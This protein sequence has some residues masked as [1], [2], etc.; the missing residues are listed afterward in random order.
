MV[1][2]PWHEI[3]PW[4]QVLG[5]DGY[6][7]TVLPSRAPGARLLG[8]PGGGTMS[9]IPGRPARLLVPDT[10]DALATLRAAFA[11]ADLLWRD[12]APASAPGSFLACPIPRVRDGHTSHLLANHM[13]ELHGAEPPVSLGARPLDSIMAVHLGWHSRQLLSPPRVAHVHVDGLE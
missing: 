11:R 1:E 6:I 12:V 9:I 7:W 10:S 13:R 2:T 3:G 5:P 4:S 8:R